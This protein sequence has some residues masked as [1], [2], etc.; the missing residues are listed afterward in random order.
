MSQHFCKV[1]NFFFIVI[2][3]L[4]ADGGY[5]INIE[6]EDHTNATRGYKIFH[7]VIYNRVLSTCTHRSTS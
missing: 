7:E 1:I 5:L 6:S 3:V 4:G 2:N